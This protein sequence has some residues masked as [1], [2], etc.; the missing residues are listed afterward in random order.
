MLVDLT[1]EL[2]FVQEGRGCRIAFERE[3]LDRWTRG[4]GGG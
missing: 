1:G 2:P 4:M 3:Q